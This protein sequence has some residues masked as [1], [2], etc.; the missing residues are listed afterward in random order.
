MWSEKIE[1]HIFSWGG[2]M[3]PFNEEIKP[4]NKNLKIKKQSLCVEKK[5]KFWHGFLD[6]DAP[7]M[8]AQKYFS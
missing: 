2:T 3:F 1:I 8:C 6:W 7:A 5:L 4:F